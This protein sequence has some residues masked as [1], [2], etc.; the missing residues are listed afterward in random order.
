MPPA[1]KSKATMDFSKGW[2]EK[3]NIFLDVSKS[4]EMSMCMG[5]LK[6]MHYPSTGV[7][8]SNFYCASH[9]F[10]QCM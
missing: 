1:G 8:M 5:E 10:L 3:K 2:S 9:F 7:R 6:N 4:V